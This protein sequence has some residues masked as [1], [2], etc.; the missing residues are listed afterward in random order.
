MS[1]S[2][3]RL[4]A[5]APDAATLLPT[6]P[7][8]RLLASLDRI[9]RIGIAGDRRLMGIDLDNVAEGV[10]R[11]TSLAREGITSPTVAQGQ[12]ELTKLVCDMIARAGALVEKEAEQFALHTTIAARNSTGDAIDLTDT[13][14][15]VA[16]APLSPTSQD[17]RPGILVTLAQHC[18]EGT[19]GR[20][21]GAMHVLHANATSPRNAAPKDAVVLPAGSLVRLAPGQGVVLH[22]QG[23]AVLDRFQA[24]KKTEAMEDVYIEAKTEG[25]TLYGPAVF[26]PID[27]T[28]VLADAHTYKPHL[29]ALT[30]ISKPSG[31]AT[32]GG[33]CLFFSL[34]CLIPSPNL[35]EEA[36]TSWP[37][38]WPQMAA[39]L[40]LVGTAA[41]SFWAQTRA[42]RRA[43]MARAAHV[44]TLPDPIVNGR[45]SA[46][47]MALVT[48]LRAPKAAWNTNPDKLATPSTTQIPKLPAHPFFQTHAHTELNFYPASTIAAQDEEDVRVVLPL[49]ALPKPEAI[50][51]H[52]TVVAMPRRSPA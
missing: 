38:S 18:P 42:T 23:N 33:L 7:L 47:L 40:G 35:P 19:F 24:P 36:Y 8:A 50:G 28:F 30:G 39:F 9:Q 6:L 13:L 45:L 41:F 2:I 49:L 4:H 37:H 25:A 22:T 43:G 1:T 27:D 51:T 17:E 34:P 48:A 11:A 5:L 46:R 20:I 3:Q 44:G 21:T 32:L 12:A 10:A 16:A 31:W 26:T 29:L 14:R 15:L 52:T